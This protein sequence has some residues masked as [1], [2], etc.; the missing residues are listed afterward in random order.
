MTGT[1]S[2]GDQKR[3]AWDATT[4]YSAPLDAH[5]LESALDV[6]PGALRLTAFED[7]SSPRPGWGDLK[8]SRA[9]E[10][11]SITPPPN[12]IRKDERVW[13]PADVLALGVALLVGF[14]LRRRKGQVSAN[15]TG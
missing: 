7:L 2:N 9:K 13:I 6:P 1:I 3:E 11:R 4:S 8:F 10:Q 14:R 5:V 12:I 15:V